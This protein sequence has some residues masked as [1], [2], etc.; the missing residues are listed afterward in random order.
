MVNISLRVLSRPDPAQLPTIYRM[1]GVDYDERVLPSICN[2]V[3][4]SVVAKFNASQL[5]TVRQ[6][7]SSLV[8]KELV[9]RARD[10]NIILDDVSITELSFGREYTAAVEAKQVAQQEAQRAFFEV[11]QAKQDKQRKIVQAQGEAEAAKMLGE[12]IMKNPGYLKLRK[13]RAAQQIAKTMAKSQNTVY[14]G[15]SSLML[16]IADKDFDINS[17]TI[18]PGKK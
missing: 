17:A 4:K 9:E 5:I 8:R 2:E 14:L 16:N 18:M 3:L 11:E 10:F 15:A 13:I 7:V 12:A 1:L 6:Q